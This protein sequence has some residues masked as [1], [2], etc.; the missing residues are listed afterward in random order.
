MNAHPLLL[1]ADC[2][3]VPVGLPVADCHLPAHT[4]GKLVDGTF[5]YI[6]L[7]GAVLVECKS[8]TS[9]DSPPPCPSRLLHND[10]L[11]DADRGVVPAHVGFVRPRLQG[12][13]RLVVVSV[14]SLLGEVGNVVVV[15]LVSPQVH[16]VVLLAVGPIRQH[17]VSKLARLDAQLDPD[18]ES[19]L[20]LEDLAEI[21]PLFKRRDGARPAGARTRPRAAA[22]E[23]TSSRKARLHGRSFAGLNRPTTARREEAE[24]TAEIEEVWPWGSRRIIHFPCLM[25]SPSSSL[26]TRG[27][28]EKWWILQSTAHCTGL[29]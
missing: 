9:K 17:P 20:G 1:F 25:L 16:Q 15:F 5:L 23:S 26:S 3:C 28:G 22:V 14:L 21:L 6:T 29:L 13:H 7:V 19:L 24:G 10:S 2:P 27:A 8:T 18:R 12:L 11:V 4:F